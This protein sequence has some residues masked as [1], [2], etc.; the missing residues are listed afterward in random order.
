MNF[1]PYG[2]QCI[3]KDDIELVCE[4]L[5]SDW[6]TQG[7]LIE[8][9]EKALAKY[10]GA[11]YAV[12][13][14]NGTVALHLAC[15]V[16]GVEKNDEVITTP[17]T[18][19]SSSNC[20]LYCDGRPVFADIDPRTLNINPNRIKEKI[21]DKTKAII[22]VHFRGEPCDMESIYEIVKANNL[23]IIEDAAHALGSKFK[24]QKIG[25]CKYSDMAIF[26]FH[27]VKHI[28]TGEGGAITT[29]NKDLYEKLLLLRTH[30]ITKAKSLFK[31]KD[32][33]PWYYEMQ[34]LGFNYRITDIQC[35][36]GVS[37]LKKLDT[38][39][40]RRREIVDIYNKA[41]SN[42]EW[43][44]TLIEGENSYNSYHLYV[45]LFDFDYIKKTRKEVFE[46]L[47][48]NNIGAQVHYIPV[49]LQPY[50]KKNLDYKYGDYPEAEAYYEKAI[51]LPLYPKMNDDDVYYVIENVLKLDNKGL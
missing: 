32:S 8:R 29:N 16:I 20:V 36:L 18:F 10:C 1:I 44:Q 49:H 22:P 21:T 11:K 33:G 35:A 4:V 13:V 38:F 23:F 27:P 39:I 41:F 15:R 12:A 47:Y 31:N 37:Q 3:N 25:N 43:I 6:L 9:F 50:Y 24:N 17:I 30:G 28:T 26:S 51:S 5:N 34:D 14:S 46:I 40:K 45:A 19:V 7:P 42:V 2:K 48:K